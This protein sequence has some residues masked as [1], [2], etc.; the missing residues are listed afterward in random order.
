VTAAVAHALRE[1]VLRRDA[2]AGGAN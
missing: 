1:D 2:N